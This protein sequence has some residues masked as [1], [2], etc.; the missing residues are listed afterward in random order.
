MDVIDSPFSPARCKHPQIFNDTLLFVDEADQ[1]SSR[2]KVLLRGIVVY[3]P[4]RQLL[5][6]IPTLSRDALRILATLSHES[7]KILKQG[8]GRSLSAVSTPAPSRPSTP[9][10]STRALVQANELALKEPP[11]TGLEFGQDL[12]QNFEYTQEFPVFPGGKGSRSPDFSS[13]CGLREQ[14]T[15]ALTGRDL[16]STGEAAHIFPHAALN[17]QKGQSVAAWRFLLIF[18][19]EPLRDV[20]AKEV[21]SQDNGIHTTRNS[22]AMVVEM[23]KMFDNGDI[24]LTPVREGSDAAKGYFID[25]KLRYHG[26]RGELHEHATKLNKSPAEQHEYVN[27]LPGKLAQSEQR[28]MEPEETIR[29][30]TND[31]EA[32]PLPSI[33]LLFWHKALWQLAKA[34]ALTHVNEPWLVAIPEQ[35]KRKRE[36]EEE[37]G[38]DEDE[39][40]EEEEEGDSSRKSEDKSDDRKR[41]GRGGRD[42]GRPPSKRGSGRPRNGGSGKGMAR[43][44]G[45]RGGEQKKRSTAELNRSTQEF[46]DGLERW[47]EMH[48]LLALSDFEY[49]TEAP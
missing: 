24:S 12:L 18:L 32:L 9:V 41:P 28:F 49:E 33:T 37:D 30:T 42:W 45:L 31:P 16:Q 39:D 13:A 15:C 47:W 34:S 14:G 4:N 38:D 40:E 19:G 46:I 26:S 22:I 35:L 1:I 11:K 23:H 25:V 2:E 20:I 48:P 3:T 43:K 29:I 8:G 6:T 5:E 44:E 17:I 7:L 21:L 36:D 27:G 10:S